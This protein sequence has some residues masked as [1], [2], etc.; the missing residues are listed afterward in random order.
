M[1]PSLVETNFPGSVYKNGKVIL[2]NNSSSTSHAEVFPTWMMGDNGDHNIGNGVTVHFVG[3]KTY[4]NVGNQNDQSLPAPTVS[5]RF[6]ARADGGNVFL[7]SNDGNL[8]GVVRQFAVPSGPLAGKHILQ[9]GSWNAMDVPGVA[10]ACTGAAGGNA[11][12]EDSLIFEY[13][14]G[15]TAAPGGW[16]MP[17]KAGSPSISDPKS[18]RDSWLEDAI[19]IARA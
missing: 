19:R 6:P 8:G 15:T 5:R 4:G 13:N 7:Q 16:F 12:R 9:E 14:L 11:L 10:I 17:E 18:W 3:A 2:L 1:R